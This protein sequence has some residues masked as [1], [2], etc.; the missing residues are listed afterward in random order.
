M[1]DRFTTYTF[2]IDDL[3]DGS[4]AIDVRAMS[5]EHNAAD[6]D[7]PPLRGLDLDFCHDRHF[8]VLR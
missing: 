4:K 6:F 2:M 7:K 8:A 1:M 3:D 5:E